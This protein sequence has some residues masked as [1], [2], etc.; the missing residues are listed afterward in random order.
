MKIV[1]SV[2]VAGMSVFL[3]CEFN[4]GVDSAGGMDLTR[5]EA[6]LPTL[7]YLRDGGARILICSHMGRP[8]GKRDPSKSL[9]QLVEPLERLLQSKIGF[10][11]DCVGAEKLE[12]QARLVPGEFLLLENVR[13]YAEE[14]A[15]DPVFGR[16]LVEGCD[17]YVNDAFGNSHRPHASMVAAARAA[18]QRCAGLLLA[19]EL[20]QLELVNDPGLRPSL[21]IIGGAKVSG[22]DGKIRVVRN[23]LQ[24]MDSVFLV[25]KLAYFFLQA[26]GIDVGT[27]L[28][29]DNRGIDAPG[30]SLEEDIQACAET[31]AEADRLSKEIILP[32]DS[33]AEG[34]DGPFVA[35]HVVNRPLAQARALDIGPETRE[36]IEGVIKKS[37]L[38]I[39]NGPAGYFERPEYKEGTLAIARAFRSYEGRVVVGGGDTIAAIGEALGERT[40]NVHVCTG[41]GAML[42]WLMGEPLA[43]VEALEDR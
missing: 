41:G 37:K 2:D 40:G 1:D 35:D 3:R 36:R 7:R 39:W 23:L 15:N 14:N 31:L 5:L 21:A 43:A 17:L 9:S 19:A 27:T 26:K 30:S 6:S 18:P 24:R 4:V 10:A 13:Y 12:K 16:A 22:K 33:I 34:P 25:G 28:E 11:D 32:S 8:W 42:T 38:V 29:S 20:E